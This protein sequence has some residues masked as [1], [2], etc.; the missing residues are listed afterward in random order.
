MSDSTAAATYNGIANCRLPIDFIANCR[1][2]IADLR[3][4]C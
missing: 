1:L 3:K 2:P 4:G